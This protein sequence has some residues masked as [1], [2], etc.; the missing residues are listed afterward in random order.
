MSP[1]STVHREK[2]LTQ[3]DL[4]APVGLQAKPSPWLVLC[5][6]LWHLLCES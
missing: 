1:L 2:K 3:P 6:E 5:E 4:L